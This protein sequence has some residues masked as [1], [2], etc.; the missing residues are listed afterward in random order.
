M[1]TATNDCIHVS[2]LIKSFRTP[3]GKKVTVLA[4]ISF[5]MQPG[6]VAI[7]GPN[8][9]GK[10][11]F[12]KTLA[13]LLFPDSGA[14]AVLGGRAGSREVL[15]RMGFLHETPVFPQFMSGR[16]FLRLVC[17]LY[18][19]S[20]DETTQRVTRVLGRVGLAGKADALIRG[21]SKGMVKRL[22]IAQALISHPELVIM[23]EPLDGLDPIGLRLF[24]EIMQVCRERKISV[25]LTTHVVRELVGY[26]DRLVFMKDG[27]IIRDAS[28]VA[29]QQE[30]GS[31]DDAYVAVMANTVSRES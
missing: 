16:A 14:M 18:G 19:L 30:F 26:A 24:R 17:E 20:A 21:Y 5:S 10:T 12:V 9:S 25:L 4:D 29:L 23:D 31:L 28:V 27:R 13:G 8:G 2:N 22:G 3:I 6:I 11:T 15:Q 1:Q 7:V